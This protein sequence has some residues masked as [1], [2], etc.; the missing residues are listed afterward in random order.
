MSRAISPG[1]HLGRYQI[2]SLIG[3][4]GM[5]EVYLAE[6]TQLGR[7]VAIKVMPSDAIS[8]E[9]ARRRLIREARAAATLDHPNICAIHEVGEADG[10]SFIVMQYVEGETLDVRIKRKPL[11][12]KDVL[13]IASQIADALTEAHAHGIIHRDIKPQN[14]MITARGN[15]KVMDF[16]LAKLVA[17]ALE[18][19]ARTMSLLTTPGAII[20]TMPYM[21]PEQIRGEPLDA[22]TDIFSFGVVLYETLSGRQPFAGESAVATASAI[23]TLDPAPLARYAQEVPPQLQDIVSKALRKDR[24]ERYQVVKDM[25]LDLKNL[26]QRL[27]FEAEL[28]RSAPPEWRSPESRGGA[29]RSGG[30]GALAEPAEHQAVDTANAK[31]LATASSAEYLATQIT[32]HKTGIAIGMAALIFAGIIITAV[33]YKYLASSVSQTAKRTAPLQ[34]MKLS[35]LTSTGTADQAV[36]SPDGKYVVHVASE[37]GRQSLRV[38]QTNTTSDVQIVTPA[39]VQYLGLSFSRDG[40][41]IY[42]V[43]TE[44]D[45]PTSNLY[46]VATLGGAP[47]RSI[48]DVDSAVSFSPDGQRLAFIRDFPNEGEKAVIVANAGGGGERKLAV[49]KLPNFFRSVSWSPDGKSIACG[50]GSFV[51]SYTT[52]VVTVSVEDGREKQIGAQSWGFMGAVAWLPDGSGLILE[53]SEQGSASS[54]ANQ[55]WFLSYPDGE[56]RR[57]TNDLNNYNGVSLTTDSNRLV[58]VQSDTVSNIWLAPG[59]EADRATQLTAGAGKRDGRL[60]IAWMPDGRIAYA[61]KA[62]GNDDIW[63]MKGD[64]TSQNQL[65]ANSRMNGHPFVS[66]DGRYILFISD[67]AG[68]PNVWRMDADGG[69]AKQLTSGSG[70]IS[71][72]CSPDGKWVTYTLLGS[73]KPTLWRVSIDGGAPQ[74]LS[75][76]YTALPAISPDGKSI[77][78]VYRDEQPNSPLKLA[79]FPFEGGKPTQIFDV[80]ISAAGNTLSLE[81]PVSWTPDGRALTYVVTA[82]GVSNIWSQP[83]AEGQTRQLTSFKSERIFWF[84]WSRDGKQLAVARG[85]R[86]SDV[87]LISNFR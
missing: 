74:Q 16:G 51:P 63:V 27:E 39:D 31:P 49:R 46:Q 47:R 87:V 70:E 71:P 84:D 65:T 11:E 58:T 67:R 56:A 75:D 32:R 86:T 48:A 64:G 82:A 76:R 79:I 52:Y 26:K 25:L 15:V 5:G 61:S 13:S 53:A 3:A 7:R 14:I 4:G 21:S 85:T 2:R 80:G 6:D 41:Y 17:G 12:L 73:G 42:F 37:S 34:T 60:G 9:N 35:R 24:E 54:D 55:I 40:D 10:R 36:I 38:R 1:T 83:L 23:L 81:P 29:L 43:A 78:C 20:G 8:D 66:P 57:V 22:R 44:K 45:S 30:L 72:Q 62:S 19:E 28:E 33:T 69:N 50:A 77:A 68:T 59:G 18:S